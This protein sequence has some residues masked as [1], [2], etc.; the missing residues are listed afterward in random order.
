MDASNP[1]ELGFLILIGLLAVFLFER[2]VAKA[3]KTF[4]FGLILFIALVLYG[5][6]NFTSKKNNLPKIEFNDILNWPTLKQK[7]VPYE[8]EAVKDIK[9]DYKEAK[10]NF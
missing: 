9:I 1:L 4:I 3:F 5:T 7:L 8:K 2:I 10:K 6:E